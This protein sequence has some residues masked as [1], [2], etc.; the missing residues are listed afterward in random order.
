[1]PGGQAG[2]GSPAAPEYPTDMLADLAVSILAELKGNDFEAPTVLSSAPS[3]TRAVR[4]ARGCCIARQ[5]PETPLSDENPFYFGRDAHGYI[6]V[7]HCRQDL[8]WP[9]GKGGRCRPV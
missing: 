1:M 8:A 6:L 3:S 2:A 9:R 4:A 7:S 5:L